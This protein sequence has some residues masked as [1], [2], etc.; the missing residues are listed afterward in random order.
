MVAS[1]AARVAAHRHRSS[2]LR[3]RRQLDADRPA[4]C[5]P[6]RMADLAGRDEWRRLV[7]GWHAMFGLLATLTGGLLVAVGRPAG[8]GL[9][10]VLCGWY[11]M[12]GG[13]ALHAEEPGHR[14]LLYVAGALPLTLVL[15]AIH[16][17][18][19]VMLFMLY[20][21][22]WSLLPVRRALVAT[23]LAVGG[24]T[25]AIVA[26][27]GL[28]PYV[29]VMVPVELLVAAGLGLWITRIIEQSRQRAQL[30]TD[31][32]ETRAALATMSR[33]AG[34]LAE[35][36]RLAR[37]IHDTLA[38]GFTSVLLLLEAAEAEKD[39]ET[40]WRHVARARRTAQDNL[41]EARALIAELAPPALRDASLPD[42]LRVLVDRVGAELAIV[43]MLT[44]A[45]ESRPLPADQEVA[46]LRVAQEALTNVRKHAAAGRVEVE[47]SYRDSDVVLQVLD[48][49][50]GF[51][52]S[53]VS[54]GF[55]LGGMRERV[56][57][58]GGVLEV[59]S[60]S[61]GTTVSV[62]MAAR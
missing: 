44:V 38:Q 26:T 32:T 55:G 22:I 45:G 2:V 47:L 31:L 37:D 14:G 35:R 60:G 9:V 53:A 43:P 34:A 6:E 20:P 17:V 51:D 21:H 11:A 57:Q 13:R 62:Q 24:T 29:L 8:L 50:C 49:G 18:G 42:A 1:L 25:A 58:V 48:D 28:A 23:L 40:A 15:F 33:R 4:G 27:A 30:V 12:T 52:P 41:A 3:I 7:A 39:T 61:D 19:A 59:R 56:T 54:G 10:A 46:L 36:E 5:D 16:A